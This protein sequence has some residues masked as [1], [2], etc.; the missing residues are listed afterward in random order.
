MQDSIWEPRQLNWYGDEGTGW[1][2]SVLFP[3]GKVFLFSQY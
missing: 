3:E 2:F 1:I